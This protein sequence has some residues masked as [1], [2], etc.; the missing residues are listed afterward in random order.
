[1]LHRHA[2]KRQLLPLKAQRHSLMMKI[3]THDLS[4]AT[5]H[6]LSKSR[7]TPVR[8]IHALRVDV[9]YMPHL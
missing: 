8:L 2:Q 7:F 9:N 6:I 5:I 1:M 4:N 3:Q